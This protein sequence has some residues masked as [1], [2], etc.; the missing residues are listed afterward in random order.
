MPDIQKCFITWKV[1]AVQQGVLGVL[2]TL[3]SLIHSHTLAHQPGKRPPEPQTTITKL[4]TAI[5][6]DH[7]ADAIH[8]ISETVQVACSLA[9]QM[10]GAG[11]SFIIT[12]STPE[13]FTDS[14]E[15][16]SI[17]STV[18]KGGSSAI[19]TVDQENHTMAAFYMFSKPNR[20]YG[21]DVIDCTSPIASFHKSI[22]IWIISSLL[23]G[24]VPSSLKDIDRR[25]L[26]GRIMEKHLT[27]VIEIPDTPGDSQ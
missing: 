26:Q 12:Q 11:F 25:A 17:L 7:T 3:A 16:K 22:V 9:R 20:L 8:N 4:S 23:L 27:Y 18:R 14:V 15:F 5:Y 19:V 13:E 6:S 10:T 1:S 21:I 2:A 24:K